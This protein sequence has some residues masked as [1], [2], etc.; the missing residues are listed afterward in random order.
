MGEMADLYADWYEGDVAQAER[1]AERAAEG[2]TFA[3]VEV[4]RETPKALLVEFTGGVRRWVPKSQVI[5]QVGLMLTVSSWLAD[6]W[7]A[8]EIANVNPVNFDCVERPDCT[9][10]RETEKALLVRLADDREAWVPKSQLVEASDLKY[11]GDAGVLRV[12][13]WYAEQKGWT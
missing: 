4:K 6:Q 8:E 5:E 9:V 10:M 13:R 3:M 12:T 7:R 1:A 11:D 2:A